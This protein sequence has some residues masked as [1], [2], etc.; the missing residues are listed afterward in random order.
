MRELITAQEVQS[1][2]KSF[3]KRDIKWNTWLFNRKV[4]KA[5]KEGKKFVDMAAPLPEGFL[6]NLRNAGYHFR[7]SPGNRWR[8]GWH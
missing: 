6:N 1:I 4:K 8:I 5:A 3:M 7:P 2:P